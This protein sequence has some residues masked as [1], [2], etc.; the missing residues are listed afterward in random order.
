MKAMVAFH[1]K[2]GRLRYLTNYESE[3]LYR[4]AQ[5]RDL[6]Y[7]SHDPYHLGGPVYEIT[8]TDK[9]EGD[10]IADLAKVADI[11]K[12]RFGNQP[13]CFLNL[14]SEDYL[15]DE[16][17]ENKFGRK[18]KAVS[19]EIIRYGGELTP[20]D[21]SVAYEDGETEQ[22]NLTQLWDKLYRRPVC[23]IA[24]PQNG[25]VQFWAAEKKEKKGKR[26]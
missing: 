21:V 14:V 2:D 5:A 25:S 10:W 23:F 20:S 18:V 15:P 6:D 1:T 7:R 19:W 12:D 22:F 9:T 8:D 4:F 16:D 24:N 11:F 13:F 3:T 26:K 17:I